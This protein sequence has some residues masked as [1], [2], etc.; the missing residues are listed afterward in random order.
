MSAVFNEFN[1]ILFWSKLNGILGQKKKV[2]VSEDLLAEVINSGAM[3]NQM[4]A[5]IEKL[6]DDF[7]KNLSLRSTSGLPK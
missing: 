6:K 7:I 4:Q 1:L 3:K 2:E 5:P